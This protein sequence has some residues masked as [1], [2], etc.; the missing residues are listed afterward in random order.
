MQFKGFKIRS[1]ASA[2]NQ[3]QGSSGVR[4]DLGVQ[5][6]PLKQQVQRPLFREGSR[7]VP[8]SDF[9][10]IIIFYSECR[11]EPTMFYKTCIVVCPFLSLKKAQQWIQGS[12]LKRNV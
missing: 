6:E 2:I 9:F 4:R 10:I 1:M 8:K 7:R 12:K 11:R 5:N 3:R